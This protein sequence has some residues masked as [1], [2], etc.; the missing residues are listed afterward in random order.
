MRHNWLE[1]AIQWELCKKLIF[2]HIFTDYIRLYHEIY[3]LKF[4]EAHTYEKARLIELELR[5]KQRM[6]RNLSR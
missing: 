1:K 3:D 5:R 6:I 4:S 2:N